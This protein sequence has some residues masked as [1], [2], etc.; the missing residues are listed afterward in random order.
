MTIE[1]EEPRKNLG[2]VRSLRWTA[3]ICVIGVALAWSTASGLGTEDEPSGSCGGA[4]ERSLPPGHPPVGAMTLPPGHPPVDGG[5]RLP[6][7]HP[8]V[9][10][11]PTL[12]P[13]HPPMTPTVGGAFPPGALYT[14]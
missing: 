3:V 13:G 1:R 6:P 9:N 10:A 7:G 12:P 2:I 11:R 4:E 5:A 8:P 14:L